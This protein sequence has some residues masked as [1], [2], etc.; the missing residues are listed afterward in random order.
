MT[1]AL[2][3][4]AHASR[5]GDPYPESQRY[6]YF[7]K[8]N[9]KELERNDRAALENMD[10]ASGLDRA[11]YYLKLESARIQARLGDYENALRSARQAIDLAPEAPEPRLFAAWVAAYGGFWD[12]AA[13]YYQEVLKL[14][15]GHLE[16]LSHLG[17][18]YAE[19]GRLKEAEATFKKMVTADPG[20]LAHYYLGSF[21][22]KSGRPGEAIAALK[23]SADKNPDFITALIDLADLY[24]RTDQRRNAEKTYERIIRLRP[25]AALPKA[26]LARLLLQ[27]GRAGEARALLQELGGPPAESGPAAHLLIG[28]VYMEQGL[29]E[30]A[31]REFEAVLQKEPRNAEALFRLAAAGLELGEIGQ[32]REKL[33]QIDQKS[34]LYVEARLLLA[35]T[36]RNDD[37]RQR[38]N[39]AL[40]IINGAVR[41]RPD[42]PRLPAAQALLLEELGQTQKARRVIVQAVRRFPRE[43]ELRFRQGVIE[44]RLGDKKASVSAMREAIRLNPEHAEALNYLAY[45]WAERRENLG[46]AL[47]LAEKADELRPDS[48][49][50][51]DTLA[52]IH[53]NLGDAQKAL[54]LL[55]RAVPLSSQDPVVLDHLGDVLVKLGRAREAIEAYRQALEGGY[56]Q[57]EKL[58]EKIR[59]LSN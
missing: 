59:R 48:G 34:D 45:T 28:R 27:E 5:G 23:I 46:E 41:A 42:A 9:F 35:S 54:D 32:A 50:I 33:G 40:E 22:A 17:A 58:N 44:D 1:A 11:S 43:A 2:A 29:F 14:V 25:A 26:R 39:E 7:I 10:L 20:Y 24:E 53:Y 31:A 16:A 36:I 18:L 6:F 55:E 51:I 3:G 19:T 38:L 47:A 56:E 8:S 49:Y 57:Q 12:E 37:P 13:G 4:C 52:W 15:P 21:Y 30:D